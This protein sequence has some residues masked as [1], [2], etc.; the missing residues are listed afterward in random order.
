[1]TRTI[2]TYPNLKDQLKCKSI[3][4][5]NIDNVIEGKALT[6]PLAYLNRSCRFRKVWDMCNMEAIEN[7]RKAKKKEYEQ[8]PKGKSVQREGNRKYYQTHK[9]KCR[10]KGRKYREEHREEYREGCRRYYQKNKMKLK[11]YRNRPEV[12]ERNRERIKRYYQRHKEKIKSHVRNTYRKK[13]NIPK[14]KWRVK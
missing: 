8:T 7:E 10:E 13:F 11:E 1:M 4:S 6:A 2:Q 14:S 5:E 9:R 12:K 3:V